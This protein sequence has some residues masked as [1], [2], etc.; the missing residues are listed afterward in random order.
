[1]HHNN[2]N[3]YSESIESLID[4]L[5][6]FGGLRGDGLITSCD[7]KTLDVCCLTGLKLPLI[8]VYRAN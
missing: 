8:L 6:S 4:V 3:S 2:V 5:L 1:M 7:T